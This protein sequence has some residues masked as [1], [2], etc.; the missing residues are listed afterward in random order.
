MYNVRR[1]LNAQ[2][3]QPEIL[4]KGIAK[5]KKGGRRRFSHGQKKSKSI[6]TL[7]VKNKR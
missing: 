1:I 2:E 7:G 6:H 3:I 4:D 5:K